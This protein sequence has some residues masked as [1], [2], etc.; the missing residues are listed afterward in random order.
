MSKNTDTESLKELS[1]LLKGD[2][3]SAVDQ[4]VEKL[5]S[6]IDELIANGETASLDFTNVRMCI[7][8]ASRLKFSE[9]TH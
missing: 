3:L 6:L 9:L 1:D 4:V 8:K 2:D 5:T 7:Y